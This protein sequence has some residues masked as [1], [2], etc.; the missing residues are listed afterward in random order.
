[1]SFSDDDLKRWKNLIKLRPQDDLQMYSACMI[2]NTKELKALLTRLEAAEMVI[3]GAHDS[4]C[5]CYEVWR[6]AKGD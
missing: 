5:G 4:S 3:T 1:M 6:K 2:I